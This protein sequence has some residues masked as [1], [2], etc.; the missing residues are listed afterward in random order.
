MR[1][2]GELREWVRRLCIPGVPDSAVAN[3]LGI[4][5]D[6]ICK[7]R[8]SLGIPAMCNQYGRIKKAEEANIS[9]RAKIIRLYA[10]NNGIGMTDAS[11]AKIL[12]MSRQSVGN[13]RRELGLETINRT[14][15]ITERQEQELTIRVCS[16]GSI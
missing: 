5:R 2:N 11:I 14:E 3:I 8:I 12:G 10:S 15:K 16:I 1:K 4:G 9:I 7:T 13:I 6:S